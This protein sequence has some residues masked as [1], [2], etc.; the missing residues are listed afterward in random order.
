MREVLSELQPM[1]Q[2]LM[3]TL[4]KLEVMAP[5]LGVAGGLFVGFVIHLL[6]RKKARTLP[7]LPSYQDTV[8][9]EHDA[10]TRFFAAV[11]DLTM[12]VT[13]AWNITH[14]RT[15][16]AGSVETNLSPSHLRQACE[17]VSEH[18]QKM[19]DGL[20]DYQDLSEQVVRTATQ[21]DR[22]WTYRSR[23]NYRTETYTVTR[24]DSDG[25]TH[26]ET[27]TRQVYEDT[28]HWFTFDASEARA[29]H[30]SLK[31]LRRMRKDAQLVPPNLQRMRV[32]LSNLSQADRMFLKKLYIQT[33]AEDPEADPTELELASVAN[34][35]LLGTRIDLGLHSFE[36]TMD[37]ALEV[38]G[39]EFRTIH[40]SRSSYHF[41]TPSRSHSGPAG[42]QAAARLKQTLRS[43]AQHWMTV[44]EMWQVCRDA[45]RSLLEWATDASEVESDRSYAQT[46]I[47]AYEAAFPASTIQVD[48]LTTP[49]KTLIISLAVAVAIGLI[50]FALHPSGRLH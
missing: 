7:F 2:D 33:I 35:W 1:A 30:T 21:L 36:Q 9:Q 3:V 25:N 14:N 12:C 27:R 18:G 5:T 50:V 46:A 44:A 32:E 24:T 19:M 29:A 43:A 22:S 41:N 31:T 4:S 11:H 13:E 28:D 15:Q 39:G 42:F 37:R 17:G 8:E 49:K 34:Q 45:A 47:D 38:G 20:T 26:T 48:Q 40:A 23:D 10:A 6:Q 16:D